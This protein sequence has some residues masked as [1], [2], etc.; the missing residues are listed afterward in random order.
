MKK[1]LFLLLVIAISGTSFAQKKKDVKTAI[2]NIPGWCCHS[3]D[4]TIENTLAYEN[5]V[6][7]WKLDKDKKQVTIT[8]K[9]GKTTPDKVE[10]AL[11]QNGVRTQ[12]YKP[13]PKAITKLP[14]C[15]QPAAR[16][17]NPNCK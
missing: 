10:K 14:K 7:D 9:E 8:Y 13:N 15:C 16:G 1:I 6:T 5:G 4:P 2:I 3:L 17:E 11:A 12:N